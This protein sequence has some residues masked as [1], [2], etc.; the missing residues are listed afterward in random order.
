MSQVRRIIAVCAFSLLSSFFYVPAADARDVT[1]G[2]RGSISDDADFGVG[3]DI[4]WTFLPDDPRLALDLTFDYFFPEEGND[5]IEDILDEVD[6]LF[7]NLPLPIDLE[8]ILDLATPERTY[9]E[10]NL[11]LTWDFT[12][13][14]A[15]IPYAGLGANYGRLETELLGFTSDEDDFGANV[16]AGMRIKDRFYVEAKQEFGGGEMF[17]LSAGVRF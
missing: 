10:A 3:A 9:W 13:G 12:R 5:D 2:L 4:R 11:N 6:G 1:F 17:V 8:E 14:G 7:P 16:L 15:V